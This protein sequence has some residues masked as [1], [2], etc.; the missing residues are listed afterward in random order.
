MLDW[1]SDLKSIY[2]L[3]STTVGQLKI[4][5]R[6]SYRRPTNELCPLYIIKG[7]KIFTEH[8]HYWAK[9]EWVNSLLNWKSKY[10]EY[11]PSSFLASYQNYYFQ[12]SWSFS[13]TFPKSAS[14]ELERGF[15]F[16]LIKVRFDVKI[17]DINRT[18]V[19]YSTQVGSWSV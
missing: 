2:Y 5:C 13:Y 6:E 11:S 1:S 17:S 7:R 16:N 10:K 9:N 19:P 8:V 3:H 4:N 18:L 15:N 12:N 14:C